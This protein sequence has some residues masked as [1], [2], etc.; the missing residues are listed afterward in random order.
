MGRL[1]F[2]LDGGRQDLPLRFETKS[3][4]SIEA[5]LPFL[6][7]L[8]RLGPLSAHTLDLCVRIEK[9][10]DKQY[11]VVWLEPRT[12]VE[13]DGGQTEASRAQGDGSAAAAAARD[14]QD[15]GSPSDPGSLDV[16]PSP[17]ARDQVIALLE[18]LGQDPRDEAVAGWVRQVG[19][20]E[21]LVKLRERAG[22]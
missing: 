15:D 4:N 21:A 9:D 6:K 16:S 11:P 2:F 17:T 14:T 22:V 1:D 3:F 7:N 19:V 13:G 10:G 20:D 5:I 8:A 12:V 18:L